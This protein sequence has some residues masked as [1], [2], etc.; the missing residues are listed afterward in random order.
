MSR[1]LI[2]DEN[3]AVL[4]EEVIL[5]ES[6]VARMRGLLGHT[7]LPKGTGMLI[8]PCRSIHMWFMKFPI[9]AVFLDEDLRVLRVS[10]NLQ[11]W[12]LAF[13]PRKTHCVLEGVAGSFSMLSPG[14]KLSLEN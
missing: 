7:S 4:L 12:K 2:Q 14:L 8:R 5:A 11:P 10:N 9:D 3:R 1:I 6:T 13:A